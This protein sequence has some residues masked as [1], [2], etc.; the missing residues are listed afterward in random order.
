M[1]EVMLRKL[2]ALE[3]ALRQRPP[4]TDT[5]TVD[6][7]TLGDVCRYARETGERVDKLAREVAKAAQR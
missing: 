1:N 4:A 5:V 2:D 6:A 3:R 7:R